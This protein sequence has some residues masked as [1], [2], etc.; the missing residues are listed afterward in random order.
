MGPEKASK[1]VNAGDPG[2]NR[3]NYRRRPQDALEC[4]HGP[5]LDLSANGMR[6]VGKKT[7]TGTVDLAIMGK[8]IDLKLKAKVVRCKKLGF[9][10]Y[11]VAVQ[12]LDDREIKRIVDWIAFW[13]TNR[14]AG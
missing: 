3:R 5:V 9:R 10:C 4:N 13:S 8:G 11:E 1:P 2:S 6:F 12:F 14:R 7:M